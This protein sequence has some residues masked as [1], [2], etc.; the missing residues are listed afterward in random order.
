MSSSIVT[1]VL[2]VIALSLVAVN[3]CLYFQAREREAY[4]NSSLAFLKGLL[5]CLHREAAAAQRKGDVEFA[6][7]IVRFEAA[8]IEA[9]AAL[10]NGS[11]NMVNE[12]VDG[13]GRDLAVFRQAQVQ[14]LVPEKK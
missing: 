14:K 8:Q 10:N 11:Y 4:A 13:V 7:L 6:A 9:Q 1:L 5:S 2:F 12:I 3:F